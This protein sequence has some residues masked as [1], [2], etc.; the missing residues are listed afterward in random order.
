ML[1]FGTFLEN[2]FV[3]SKKIVFILLSFCFFFIKLTA[4]EHPQ[5][6]LVFDKL[7]HDF[8]DILLSDGKKSCTF[9]YTNKGKQPIV[10]QIVIASCGC[11]VPVW[12]KAPIMPGKSGIISVT[13]QN[14]L[15]P[16]PFDKTIS[17]YSTASDFPIVLRIRGVVHE[18]AKSISQLF[19][20]AHG[21][22]LLRKSQ[23]QLGQIAQGEVKTDSVQIINAG[24]SAIEVG[25]KDV[26]KG[27]IIS[28]NPK[29]L[30]SGEKGFM[31]Y[32]VD[33]RVQPDWGTITYSAQPLVNG[34]VENPIPIVITVD[35]RDNFI[36]Y[37]K[38]QLQNAPILLAEHTSYR[39]E[40]I[41][42]GSIIEKQ[43]VITN[44]GKSPLV[45]HKA[46]P[47]HDYTIVNLP[48]SIAPEKNGTI[49]LLVNSDKLI[50][51][52]VTGATIITNVPSR[53]IFSLMITGTVAP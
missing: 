25:F 48:S 26:S 23:F 32:S 4:Q 52:F 37:S 33:T 34:K 17:V 9:T 50:G 30:K 41:K 21:P 8:G 20:I 40:N 18:K 29:K 47:S 3:M 42:Q 49:T 46:T 27:L 36:N 13:Y 15:G 38:E 43:F 14:D 7:V 45:F 31:R 5:T 22:F 53:P 1:N 35:I 2:L 28:I 39:T 6:D 11:T 24:K 10:I 19:P 44:K 51:E 12:D 16:Y